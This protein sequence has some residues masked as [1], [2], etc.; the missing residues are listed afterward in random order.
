MVDQVSY[1]SHTNG[2]FAKY[3]TLKFPD[4]IK[5]NTG[6]IMFKAKNGL[7]PSRLSRLFDLN[8]GSTRQSGKF[9]VK[10]SRTEMKSFCISMAGVKLWNSLSE[11]IRLSRSKSLFKVNFKRHLISS[12]V[13]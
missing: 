8:V 1:H 6:I 9:V 10:Y 12:Y 3:K 13:I 2:I 4:I 7:L 5:L 11:T